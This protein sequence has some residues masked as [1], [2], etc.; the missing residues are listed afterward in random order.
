LIEVN[1]PDFAEGES[2]RR[3]IG[4]EQKCVNGGM[5]DRQQRLRGRRGGR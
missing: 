5:A 4:T 3:T 1:F 2:M